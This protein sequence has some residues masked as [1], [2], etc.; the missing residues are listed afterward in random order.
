[1]RRS[2]PSTRFRRLGALAALAA[3]V[4]AACFGLQA[5]A[6][7]SQPTQSHAATAR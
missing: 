7:P 5:H 2:L 1:M 3:L 4:A 6:E